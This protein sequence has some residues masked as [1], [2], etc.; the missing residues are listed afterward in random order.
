MAHRDAFD[1]FFQCQGPL[2]GRP[3]K[4]VGDRYLHCDQYGRCLDFAA[5]RDWPGFNC[6]LCPY[7]NK[8]KLYFRF[9]D[10]DPLGDGLNDAATAFYS[11]ELQLD[12]WMTLRANQEDLLLTLIEKGFTDEA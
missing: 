5:A 4:G 9:S 1:T 12:Q 3:E 7:E 2:V 10:F 8:G 11:D 6:Q